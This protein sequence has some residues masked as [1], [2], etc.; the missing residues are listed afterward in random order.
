[1]KR[2]LIGASIGAIIGMLALAATG[3]IAGYVYGGEA[4]G[5]PSRPP[6]LAAALVGAFVYSA[7]FWW[8]A[9]A[10]GAFIGGVAGLGSWLVRPRAPVQRVRSC[11]HFP[12]DD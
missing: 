7:Y 11:G 5:P 8:L 3:A 1:M 4:V 12:R 2:S 6:G 9:G 10:I